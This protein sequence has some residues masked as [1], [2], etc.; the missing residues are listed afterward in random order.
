MMAKAKR[1]SGVCQCGAHA[2]FGL[3]RGFVALADARQH[4]KLR[5]IGSWWADSGG[6]ALAKRGGQ[7]LR[8]H[9]VVMGATDLSMEVD[10]INGRPW[11]NRTSNLRVCS[12]SRNQRNKTS[13]KNKNGFKGVLYEAKYGRYRAQIIVKG[14]NIK[15]CSRQTAAEAARDY[16]ELALMHHG[17]Y[18]KTNAAMGL[19]LLTC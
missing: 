2:Y 18:A 8:M 4:D 3:T 1:P 11:D 12:H 19:M 14:Q 17:K 5:A 13:K 10:H 15:G 9:R 7:T 6:Y 16:D